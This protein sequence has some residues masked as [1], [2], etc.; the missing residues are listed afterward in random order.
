M[1]IIVEFD[2]TVVRFISENINSQMLD[3]I[4]RF[5]S[6]MGDMGALWFGI[7]FTLIFMGGEKRK[8][9]YLMLASFALEAVMCNVVLKPSIARIRPNDALGL[10]LI[11]KKPTDYSFPSG[12]TAAAFASATSLYL[13]D[14]EKGKFLFIPAILTA[15]SRVYLLVHYPTDVIAGAIIG[16]ISAI[17][18]HKADKRAKRKKLKEKKKRA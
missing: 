3:Y 6:S 17:S 5:V 10:E 16:I 2:K 15:I 18:V 7:A 1:E 14:K 11:I 4:M 12:H 8:A 13:S 9:G